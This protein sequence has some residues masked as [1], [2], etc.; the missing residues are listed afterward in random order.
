[1]KKICA[2]ILAVVASSL[3]FNAFAD[4]VSNIDTD[5]YVSA[6]VNKTGNVIRFMPNNTNVWIAITQGEVTSI[7]WHATPA[8]PIRIQGLASMGKYQNICPD[9]ANTHDG[10]SIIIQIS[11]KAENAGDFYCTLEPA[12]SG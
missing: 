5:D 4:A 6:I 9:I 1:M 3:A 7:F 10:Q 11:E 8:I 12:V 2:L